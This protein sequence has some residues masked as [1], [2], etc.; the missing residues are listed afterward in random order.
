MLIAVIPARGNSQGVRKKNIQTIGGKSLVNLAVELS[1]GSHLVDLTILTTD[2]KEIVS[3]AGQFSHY[4]DIFEKLDYGELRDLSSKMILHKRRSEHARSNSKTVDAVLEIIQK[5]EFSR[6]DLIL[7][8]QPTSPFRQT[9][10]IEK[11]L[12]LHKSE[13]TADAVISAKLFDSP[14]PGKAI[15]IQGNRMLYDEKLVNN[16]SSP[17][18]E[19]P[20]YYVFDGAYYLTTVK[21]ILQNNSFISKE[22]AIFIR[23]GIST[24]NIDNETDLELARLAFAQT[25]KS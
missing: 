4:E 3:N 8:L 24:I 21:N 16:L 12:S 13:K 14:H 17:R 2:D 18:Q 15:R 6:E 25:K 7:L 11:L 20:N 22:T 23:E 19:L 10:E 1:L 9:N 5:K